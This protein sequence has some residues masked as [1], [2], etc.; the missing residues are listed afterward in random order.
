MQ[1]G[2]CV[3]AGDGGEGT[4]GTDYKVI[5]GVEDSETCQAKCAEDATCLAV[6][7]TVDIKECRHWFVDVAGD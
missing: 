1:V 7:W 6:G 3:R 2:K 5:A 4:A